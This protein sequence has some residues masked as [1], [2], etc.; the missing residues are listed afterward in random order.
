MV[1][2]AVACFWV[3]S[4]VCSVL[5]AGEAYR[6]VSLPIPEG[7]KL[8]VS[9]LAMLPD[10]RLAAAIRKGEVWLIENPL[11]VSGETVRYHLF[12]SGLHEP[13]GL[14]F[15]DDSLFVAQRS[16]LTRLRDRDGD[17]QADEYLTF[18]SG[19]GVTGNYHE[20]VYGP[21]F[22]DDG[23]MWMTLN[24]KLG[25]G[26]TTDDAWRGW[27][28]KI[29]PDGQWEPI[30]GGLRSPCGIGKNLDG[31]I[32]ATDHQGN[33]VPTNALVHLRPGVFHGHADALAHTQRPGATFHYEGDL[34]QG[35]PYPEALRRIPVL[36]PPA[37]WFP[38]RKMGQGVTDVLCDTTAGR[39]GP[40]AGQL[41]VGDFTTSAIFRVFLERVDGEYQGACFPFL[42]GFEC[43]AL[44]L[45]F[46]PDGSLMVGET[47]RGWN[48]LGT[49]SYGLERV[50]WSGRVPLEVLQMS[51]RPD[52]FELAFTEAVDAVTAARTDSYRL[53]SYTYL[54]RSA[55]GSPEIDPAELPVRAARPSAD[56]RSVRLQVEGLRE[57]Y[58]HELHLV[59]LSGQSGQPLDR[60]RMY[61][62]LNR[63]PRE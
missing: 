45:E 11:D 27:S 62:T 21:Q 47:N 51:A 31:A 20:Y 13:L 36:R 15:R 22:D 58:V 16:E 56:G 24:A 35:I 63:V 8:E 46:A 7:L 59:G 12:A 39:F 3:L 1:G 10:G 48:S 53:T 33:W 6:I 5:G 54:Y 41:L 28:L 60:R 43:A 49:R 40:F 18:A 2:R 44:R 29:A 55:Y 32:F 17:G 19:W 34:P 30:S 25:R 42:E 61:Y 52:G 4:S 38:Y 37:V 23:N 26:V 14:A 57:G 50:L 9:G